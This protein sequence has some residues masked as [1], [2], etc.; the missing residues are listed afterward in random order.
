MSTHRLAI[1]ATLAALSLGTLGWS[2]AS[3]ES[4]DRPV[5]AP[6]AASMYGVDPVHSSV[7]FKIKHA[8][9]TNFYG[10]FDKMTG[11]WTFDPDD[12]STASFE[13][14]IDNA[15]VN[16]GSNKRNNHLKSADFF[17]VK[18]FP[19]TSFKSTKL[20][21]VSGSMYTLTGE[22]TLHGETHTVT[23][24]LEYL[25]EG[26]FGGHDL[27]AFEAIFTINRRDFGMTTYGAADGSDTGVLGNTVKILI[28]VEGP[29]Q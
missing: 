18:Q 28:S 23:A 21:S 4:A 9:V 14:E 19:T 25:G 29:K 3:R 12:L 10:R 11:S 2:V 20:E 7:I 6:S 5:E 26:S 1:V 22:L 16:T 8:G 24:D 17:N 27:A 15:T 13:F